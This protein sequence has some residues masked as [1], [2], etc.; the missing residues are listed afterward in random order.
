MTQ[1]EIPL[2]AAKGNRIADPSELGRWGT[3]RFSLPEKVSTQT[4]ESMARRSGGANKTTVRN[5][6]T[7]GAKFLAS[8]F[9]SSTVQA[10]FFW[11]IHDKKMSCTIPCEVRIARRSSAEWRAKLHAVC[12]NALCCVG[13]IRWV[14][15]ADLG[16]GEGP[17]SPASEKTY[18]AESRKIFTGEVYF[19]IVAIR[20]VHSS[21]FEAAGVLA[22]AFRAATAQEQ[23]VSCQSVPFNPTV[24]IARR[25]T[26]F[27]P[28]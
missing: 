20:Q 17:P 21:Q 28:A 14:L 26:D 1:K 11:S 25:P 3:K 16:V 10:S 27:L 6:G 15:L 8:G 5:D 9:D 24:A 4:W 12:P 18:C 22:C 2:A 19:E 13:H 23:R 7:C